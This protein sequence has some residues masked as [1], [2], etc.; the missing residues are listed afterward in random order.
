MGWCSGG[1]CIATRQEPAPFQAKLAGALSLM[2]WTGVMICGR[3]IG[4]IEPPLEKLHALL[5]F[6]MVGAAAPWLIRFC[7]WL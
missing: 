7:A 3:G 4:Y 5:L 1:A 6:K 2:L